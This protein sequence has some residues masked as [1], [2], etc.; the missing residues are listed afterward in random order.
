MFMD[1]K[2][3]VLIPLTMTLSKAKAQTWNGIWI[4]IWTMWERVLLLS[5]L[6]MHSS[7]RKQRQE[8]TKASDKL[9]AYIKGYQRAQ[10]SQLDSNH[11]PS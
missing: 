1:I 3:F 11:R 8:N 6:S 4:W 9:D 2:L 7:Q 5:H 10:K